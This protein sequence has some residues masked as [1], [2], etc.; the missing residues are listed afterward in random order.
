M[1]TE[2]I[3]ADY[4]N[5]FSPE[6]VDNSTSSYDMTE[7]R[8]VNVTNTSGLPRLEIE[9]K[10]KDAFLRM[11]DSYLQIQYQI[12][13][14]TNPPTNLTAA[15]D[16]CLQ[17][18]A[19]SL[20][21]DSYLY[22]EDQLIESCTQPYLAHT[23]KNLSEFS[24][25]HME[26]ISQNQHLFIETGDE[27]ASSNRATQV[28]FYNNT[29]PRIGVELIFIQN[30]QFKL[31]P[32]VATSATT[33]IQNDSIVARIGHFNGPIVNFMF[34]AAAANPNSAA[35]PCSASL[36]TGAGLLSFSTIATPP[37]LLA[38]N[39]VVQ[40]TV[41]NNFNAITLY[42]SI[43]GAADVAAGAL[44]STAGGTPVV[45]TNSN[46]AILYGQS[47]ASFINS[48][49]D[50]FDKRCKLA[51]TGLPVSVWIPLKNIFGFMKAFDKI[52][53]GVRWRLVFNKESDQQSI[54]RDPNVVADRTV[55][56][57]YISC[58]V[59]RLKPSMQVL[60]VIEKELASEK[61]FDV[62]F[63]DLNIYRNPQAYITNANN[64]SFQLA[65]TVKRPVGV[66]VVFQKAER[67]SDSQIVNRRNFDLLGTTSLQ[68]RYN[69]MT[70][71]LYQYL[72]NYNSVTPIG[73]SSLPLPNAGINRLYNAFLESGYK[74]HGY[75]HSSP[76]TLD[77]FVKLYPI[78]YIDLHDQPDDLFKSQKSAE[79]TILFNN[80][81]M[82][83]GA[84]AN[85]YYVYC[86]VESERSLK[87]KA[88]SGNLA[89]LL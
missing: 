26:S 45:G 20:F 46:G 88:I 8:E 43:A 63:T 35:A 49:N 68:L 5:I 79:L 19:L 87:M 18:N 15:E 64:T 1:T 80:A 28:R 4:W 21:K 42:N 14:N 11:H 59:P 61:T 67:I 86:I 58:W 65:T 53:R 85:G 44:V 71:P 16:T 38:N 13:Q 41:N 69:G 74:M 10:D 78:F 55:T 77:S 75:D 57:Q 22:C 84:T 31:I 81:A 82:T 50:G 89:L 23:I 30:A 70:Y 66:Y 36:T 40:F 39:N 62:H 9:T 3:T 52:T 12:Q 27:P 17:N 25:P 72:L 2:S 47:Y 60:E 33:W 76:V 83:N 51:G 73:A 7:Y 54:L 6:I 32:T 34:L 37:V 56:I 29:S 24:K 48:F